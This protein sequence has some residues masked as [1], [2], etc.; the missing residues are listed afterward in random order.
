MSARPATTLLGAL[1]ALTSLAAVV[2]AESSATKARGALLD[3]LRLQRAQLEVARAQEA[4][5]GTDLDDAIARAERANHAARRIEAVTAR[6]VSLLEAAR[7]DADIVIAA[8][9]RSLRSLKT[10]R[11]DAGTAAELLA[12]LAAHQRDSAGSAAV[13][14]H[15]L[16]RILAALER[17]NRSLPGPLELR[18]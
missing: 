11:A 1:L 2:L 9:R 6:I 17:L 13:T 4:L 3:A 7:A 8:A 18:R 10:T 5:G 16:A 15:A 12:A 14:N